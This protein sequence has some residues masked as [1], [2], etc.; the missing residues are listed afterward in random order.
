MAELHEYIRAWQAVR[1]SPALWRMILEK[2]KVEKS[3]L[4]LNQ[5]DENGREA[6]QLSNDLVYI[7]DIL[8]QNELYR[9]YVNAKEAYT[10]KCK[11]AQK[12]SARPCAQCGGH[13]R[14]VSRNGES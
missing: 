3:L 2:E 6:I 14:K 7:E 11:Q 10:E 8:S 13:C 9:T 1:K 12:P 5:S 4:A